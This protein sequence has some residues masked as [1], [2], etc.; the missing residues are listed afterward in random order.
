VNKFEGA[1]PNVAVDESVAVKCSQSIGDQPKVSERY[2]RVLSEPLDVVLRL[3]VACGIRNDQ[4][5]AFVVA[6]HA[7]S[8][9]WKGGMMSRI[10][11]EQGLCFL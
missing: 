9:F 4:A 6:E 10:E 8:H 3:F 2:F 1:S 7:L 11:A 5:H